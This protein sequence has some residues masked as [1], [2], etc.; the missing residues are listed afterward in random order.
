MDTFYPPHS[1]DLHSISEEPSTSAVDP[2]VP[3]GVLT[4]EPST[5]GAQC[6]EQLPEERYAEPFLG[7][8]QTRHPEADT[9]GNGGDAA[10]GPGPS[11][12]TRRRCPQFAVEHLDPAEVRRLRQTLSYMSQ[13]SAKAPQAGQEQGA[14]GPEATF[15]VGE[16][17]DFEKMLK[18]YGRQ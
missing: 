13:H 6:V 12:G 11:P 17:F 14:D 10:N 16:N 2:Q 18:S 4:E 7:V 1:S 15:D 9:F 5:D 3:P 8:P